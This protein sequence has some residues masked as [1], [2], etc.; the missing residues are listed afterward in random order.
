[1]E[2]RGIRFKPIRKDMRRK[3]NVSLGVVLKWRVFVTD[4]V[5]L[6]TVPYNSNA[7]L[8]LVKAIATSVTLS[9]EHI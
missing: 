7:S 6:L 2:G 5:C 9:M 1:M 4:D 3:G 8:L